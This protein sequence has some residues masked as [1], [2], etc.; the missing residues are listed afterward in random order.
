VRAA[1]RYSQLQVAKAGVLKELRDRLK[2]LGKKLNNLADLMDSEAKLQSQLLD[3]LADIQQVY[4]TRY[5]Q[6]F[7][8]V[9]GKCEEA[10]AEIDNL[11][12]S[13][14][15]RTVAE[16]ASMDAL[17]STDLAALESDVAGC[18]VGL[19]ESTLDRNAVERALKDRPQP[20]G[21][22][23]HVDEAEAWVERAEQ[24]RSASKG[25]LRSALV[26]M[27]NLLRQPALST[28]LRQGEQEPFIAEVLKALDAEKLAGLLAER[29]SADKAGAKL[30]AKHLKRIVVKVVRLQ[31]FRPSKGTLEKG[32]IETVVGEFRKFLEAAVN[33]DG[34]GQSTIVEIR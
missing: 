15:Y 19:F 29:I 5:L 4:R 1:Q 26:G 30:L 8:E 2:G 20:E 31:D 32:D 13:P 17:G 27:A 7:D 12:D 34:A 18:K 33:G 16:M 14:E 11:P 10:R 21:C 9:T 3:P 24:A 28:L 6:A 25:R 23:L 22:P